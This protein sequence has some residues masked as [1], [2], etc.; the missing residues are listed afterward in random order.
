MFRSKDLAEQYRHYLARHVV[1]VLRG[2]HLVCETC[3]RYW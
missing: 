3:K 2:G 1:G